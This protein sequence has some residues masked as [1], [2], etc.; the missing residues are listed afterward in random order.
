M[1]LIYACGGGILTHPT[2]PATGVRSLHQAWEAAAAGISLA[3]FA[4]SH[5]ELRSALE[6]FAA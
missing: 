3:E 2:G 4:K 6:A 1:D 5:E